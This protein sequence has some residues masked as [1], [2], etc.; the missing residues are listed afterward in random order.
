MTRFAQIIFIVVLLGGCVSSA[1]RLGN[2]YRIVH[3]TED[4]RGA[5]GQF[6]GVIDFKDL[7]CGQQRLG[8]AD[9]YSISPSGHFALFKDEETHQLMLFDRQTS[10]LREVE[11]DTYHIP[12]RSKWREPAGVVEVYHVNEAACSHIALNH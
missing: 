7:Y 2:G 3:H 10:K 4:M 6:E 9:Y 8:T 11:D 1:D 12:R 5:A